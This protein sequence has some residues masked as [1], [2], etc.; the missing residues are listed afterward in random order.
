V[1]STLER[2][3][4]ILK[5]D[6]YVNGGL[7]DVRSIASTA[8]QDGGLPIL[9]GNC[10]MHRQ[11]SFYQANWPE[12]TTVAEDGDV[13]AFYLPPIDPAEGRPLLVAGEFAAAF[14]DRPEVQ[15]FQAFLASPEWSNAKAPVSGPGWLSANSELDV[16]LLESPIDQLSAEL[17]RDEEAVARFDASD[18]MPGEVGSGTFWREMTEWI[19]SDKP[20]DQVLDAIE[21]S[22]P[23]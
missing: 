23:Q 22:W 15:A 20:D 1:A 17:L 21:Q 11:A 12:G 9:E 8:F 5:N 13:F 10:W 16:S 2:V 19:A 7:G 18:L 14:D 6:D 4:T 3:G